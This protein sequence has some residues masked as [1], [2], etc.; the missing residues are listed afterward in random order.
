ML[1][2]IINFKSM[3]LLAL[4]FVSSLQSCSSTNEQKSEI[5]GQENLSNES[6]KEEDLSN[7]ETANANEAIA[8]GDSLNG[9]EAD[10]D[11]GFEGIDTQALLVDETANPDDSQQFIDAIENTDSFTNNEFL[12]EGDDLIEGELPNQINNSQ[13]VNP[14]NNS[15]VLNN[16]PTLD[17]NLLA[18]DT[19]LFEENANLLADNN[20]AAQTSETNEEIP[21][22][23]EDVL[24]TRHSLTWVG[25]EYSKENRT[26]KVEMVTKGNPEYKIFSEK[27]QAGQLEYVVRFYQ[28][29][30]RRKVKW[31]IDASEFRSPVAYIRMRENSID[32][33]SDV[34]LTMRSQVSPKFFA[35]DGDVVLRFDIPDAY[36]GNEIITAA[37]PQET[38]QD[39]QVKGL[40][41]N[42]EQGSDLPKSE[43][44]ADPVFNQPEAISNTI[45]EQFEDLSAQ[46]GQNAFVNETNSLNNG[47]I[48]NIAS[49]NL[50]SDFDTN[51]NQGAIVNPID[52]G[53]TSNSN[54]PNNIG[55]VMNNLSDPNEAL[56]SPTNNNEPVD[57]NLNQNGE[58]D[59]LDGE[60]FNDLDIDAVEHVRKLFP[61]QR[62]AI[63]SYQVG[64]VAQ[65]DF[66]E[67]NLEGNE[68]GFDVG[69]ENFSNAENPFEGNSDLASENIG[70]EQNSNQS[71]NQ[72]SEPI[73]VNNANNELPIEANFN[74]VQP[75][76]E[77]VT[78]TDGAFP[79]NNV[80]VDAAAQNAIPSEPSNPTTEANVVDFV[81]EENIV[82][83]NG[84]SNLVD[85]PQN[86]IEGQAST[87]A[88]DDFGGDF[89]TLDFFQAPLSSVFA[90]LTEETGN[91]FI[92]PQEIAEKL[93]TI[94]FKKV[95]WDKALKAILETF[96][97]GMIKIGENLVRVDTVDNLTQYLTKVE[98]ARNLEARRVP[99][100][101]LVMR[102]NNA[103]A[104]KMIERVGPIIATNKQLD[105]RVQIAADERTN[106]LILEAPEH[107]LSKVQNIVSR[108]DLETPQVEITSRIV[109]VKKDTNNIAGMSI[110]NRALTNFDPGR[111][112][113]FGTLN[114]PNSV[115]S[116]FS[117]DPAIRGQQQVGSAQFRIGSINKVIDL[118]LI[119]KLEERRGSTNVLQRNRVLVLDNETANI[120]SGES[121][122][123]PSAIVGGNE[124]ENNGLSE[125]TFNLEL[126]VKPQVTADGAV[127][128]DLNITSDTP[129]DRTGPEAASKNS[130][131][132]NTKMLRN[133]GDTGVIGGIVNT[134]VTE[135]QIGIPF[136]SRLP[137]I[138]ALFRRTSKT[139]SQTELLIMVTPKIIG[140]NS[141]QDTSVGSALDD[142]G[143]S[144]ISSNID[145]SLD[146]A[147]I[148][149]NTDNGF[150]ETNISSNVD[151]SFG[152]DSFGS[153]ATGVGNIEAGSENLELG[154]ESDDLGV[155]SE[156]IL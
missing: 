14:L 4:L 82:M 120:L 70:T 21:A 69:E 134:Q 63:E 102:L 23:E 122:F 117:V 106:S 104:A 84:F 44:K 29:S 147:N 89:L 27:N 112:L 30:L 138:G 51:L 94:T 47:A 1:S 133:S 38:A 16:N 78:T 125:V 136:I 64:A 80:A 91:N 13:N 49:D 39:L 119:L 86:E 95:P 146:G 101:I 35:K 121:K 65:D 116:T 48:D 52:I 140:R 43:K 151:N 53:D 20:A 33:V 143:V 123:F 25:Y 34:V 110:L 50:N 71:L 24:P 68:F 154:P 77:N 66:G 57:S 2:V 114:F 156:D 19:P 3:L 131:E 145:D 113:G 85:L 153:N 54:G 28:T 105:S 87:Q 107:V 99:T 141:P 108:L 32:G 7:F 12:G 76:S 132:L 40:A 41:V 26:L 42:I 98:Q 18:E 115:I 59:N 60:Q 139:E 137:I 81:P 83:D 126:K 144:N 45:D 103:K 36:F 37:T 149:G 128:M 111:G 5:E 75:V 142:F 15:L 31:D 100:K 17:E 22:E 79:E 124:G 46:N 150:G 130:R 129:G 97:L 9:L 58:L 8:E 88:P 74:D 155:D 55:S 127:L 6:G 10:G 92:Y 118:D 135:A 56:N 152:D 73:P 90:V 96:G 148:F 72:N 67:E 62:Y 109:E 11:E 93:V 61:E